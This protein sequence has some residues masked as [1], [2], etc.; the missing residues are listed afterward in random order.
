MMFDNYWSV[1]TPEEAKDYFRNHFGEPVLCKREDG[2]Q[3]LT[4]T[5]ADAKAFFKYQVV[6]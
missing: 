1:K 3:R 4:D 6:A 2:H 5:Y